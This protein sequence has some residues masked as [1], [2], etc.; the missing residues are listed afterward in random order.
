MTL[1]DRIFERCARASR[2]STPIRNC[3]EYDG[4]ST[5]GEPNNCFD[6]HVHRREDLRTTPRTIIDTARRF[7]DV[8]GPV[9]GGGQ[10]CPP[11][12]QRVEFAHIGGGHVGSAHA[13]QT[14]AHM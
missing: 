8:V 11:Y 2:L 12:Q 7:F 14:T 13:K 3:C 4:H 10:R 1:A 6:G 5:F 9:D